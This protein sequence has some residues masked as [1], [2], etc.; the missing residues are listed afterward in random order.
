MKV[1]E[2]RTDRI[3][4]VLLGIVLISMV[5][6]GPQSVWGWAGLIPLLTGLVGYCPL[7]SLLGVNTCGCNKSDG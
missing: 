5:F 4:R 1:N 7:Y 3:V 6:V 2:G